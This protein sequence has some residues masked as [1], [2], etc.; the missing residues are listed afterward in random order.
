[1]KF[2]EKQRNDLSEYFKNKNIN[3]RFFSTTFKEYSIYFTWDCLRIEKELPGYGYKVLLYFNPEGSYKKTSYFS[4]EDW[5]RLKS[6]IAKIQKILRPN[7]VNFI[8]GN[9]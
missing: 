1:M 4:S 5:S 7:S 6:K 3:P 2:T 9:K 8:I